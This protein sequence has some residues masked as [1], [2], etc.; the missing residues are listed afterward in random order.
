[1]RGNDKIRQTAKTLLGLSM[2]EDQ[3]SSERV[4]A[5][6]RALD[7]RP[8]RHYRPVLREYL[9]LVRKQVERNQARVQYAGP[10]PPDLINNIEASLSAYYGRPITATAEEHQDLIAG[11]R[12]H[13]ASDVY[14]SSI[15]NHLNQMAR[16]T[17]GR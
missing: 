5:V 2:E 4:T 8:P 6:L 3:V 12:I 16:A 13:V 1:M 11:L 7:A 10:L 14:D 17:T 9:R 15:R